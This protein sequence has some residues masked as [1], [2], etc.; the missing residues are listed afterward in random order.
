MDRHSGSRLSYFVYSGDKLLSF[1]HTAKRSLSAFINDPQSNHHSITGFIDVLLSYHSKR[2]VASISVLTLMSYFE[3]CREYRLQQDQ[4][5]TLQDKLAVVKQLFD[6]D[7]KKKSRDSSP[8]MDSNDEAISIIYGAPQMH[9][10]SRPLQP[11]SQPFPPPQHHHHHQHHSDR[12]PNRPPPAASQQTVRRRF[13][14]NVPPPKH[15]A[16]SVRHPLSPQRPMVPHPMDKSKSHPVPS[17]PTKG[18]QSHSAGPSGGGRSKSDH[19]DRD[20]DDEEAPNNGETTPVLS[21]IDDIDHHLAV[22]GNHGA[23]TLQ[24]GG[25]DSDARSEVTEMTEMS[26]TPQPADMANTVIPSFM[27]NTL[28]HRNYMLCRC[29]WHLVYFYTKN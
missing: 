2:G 10:A 14:Q 4:M 28:H 13:V 12:T 27:P 21:D 15:E 9:S 6:D 29:K 24:H 23:M 5:R 7:F 17:S 1:L 20:R 8:S 3:L 19:S 25:Y 26:A 16:L 18:S 11:R 22:G